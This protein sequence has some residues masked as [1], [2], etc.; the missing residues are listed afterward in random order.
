MWKSFCPIKC[1][2]AL[3]S[4][5]LGARISFLQK[6][7]FDWLGEKV[8]IIPFSR[9]RVQ[10]T[11]LAA[12]SGHSNCLCWSVLVQ[13][14]E[15]CT[16][17]CVEKEYV[18]SPNFLTSHWVWHMPFV[19]FKRV[20]ERGLERNEGQKLRG[21]ANK[22]AVASLSARDLNDS[23]SIKK[24]CVEQRKGKKNPKLVSFLELENL[25]RIQLITAAE[26]PFSECRKVMRM[27]LLQF[28]PLDP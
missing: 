4:F 25:R 10:H 19:H 24:L 28:S 18:F 23:S 7:G 14:L 26:N 1:P 22:C 13:I 2:E 15:A 12:G 20:Y 5:L 27:F 17:S 11:C 8:V 3:F 6:N 9:E 16:S 21:Y